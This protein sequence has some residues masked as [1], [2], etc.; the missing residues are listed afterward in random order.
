MSAF[1]GPIHY[2][3]FNKIALQD[4]M[5]EA[6]LDLNDEN[7]YV[8]GLREKTD[9]EC[10]FIEQ[11]PLEDMIDESNIH[12]WLQH[13][14]N[15]VERRLAYVVT[16]ILEKDQEAFSAI[17]KKMYDLGVATYEKQ[18]N[19]MDSAEQVYQKM[20]DMLLDGMPCDH[21]NELVSANSSEVVYRRTICI[22][23]TYWTQV[24]GTVQNYYLIRTKFMDGFLQNSDFSFRADEAGNYHIMRK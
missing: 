5:V 23:E 17:E 20:N 18:E 21:V 4:K 24:G 13:K 6:V 19:T 12:G 15:I 16:S 2:W 10:G 9:E 3:L 8:D 1:L 7:H 14:V 11:K 22:H